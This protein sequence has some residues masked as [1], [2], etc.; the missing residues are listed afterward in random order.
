MRLLKS[1]IFKT[2][3]IIG[4]TIMIIG[5]VQSIYELIGK[6]D[7]IRYRQEQVSKLEMENKNLKI[8]LE[9]AQN[10]VFLEKEVRNRLG[11][12]K[13]GETL[14]LMEE[15]RTSIS[16]EIKSIDKSPWEMWVELFL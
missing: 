14:V 11:L 16:G 15:I 6:R 3:I 1:K 12:V 5:L 9:E 8:A 7:V 10:Q 2:L 13:P 4:S